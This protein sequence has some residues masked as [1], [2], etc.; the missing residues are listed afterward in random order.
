M[1]KRLLFLASFFFPTRTDGISKFIQQFLDRRCRLSS[2]GYK[3]LAQNW[4]NQPV[5]DVVWT[6]AND[7]I[8]NP[9]TMKLITGLILLFAC[10]VCT[11][12]RAPG[13]SGKQ[14]AKRHLGIVNQAV[15]FAGDVIKKPFEL[16]FG[17]HSKERHHHARPVVIHPVAKLYYVVTVQSPRNAKF[18]DFIHK[19]MEIA[20]NSR[21]L[22]MDI[23]T[24]LLVTYSKNFNLFIFVFIFKFIRCEICWT[25]RKPPYP[26]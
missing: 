15:D 16:L 13:G 4:D 19:L 2:E 17:H 11:Y 5:F 12:S 21:L 20:V 18:D 9:V 23:A 3:Y 24:N 14:L 1:E 25:I 8:L 10:A 7:T 22:N 6:A 26:R